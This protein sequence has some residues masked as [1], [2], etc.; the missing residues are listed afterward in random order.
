MTDEQVP[1]FD[2]PE[3]PKPAA[4]PTPQPQSPTTPYSEDPIDFSDQY[5]FDLRYWTY[6]DNLP[7]EIEHLLTAEHYANNGASTVWHMRRSGIPKDDLVKR[8]HERMPW[9]VREMTKHWLSELTVHYFETYGEDRFK[10]LYSHYEQCQDWLSRHGHADS[11]HPKVS[12]A[13]VRTRIDSER[14]ARD[15]ALLTQKREEVRKLERQ[16]EE[17]E[18]KTGESR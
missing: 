6:P 2:Q 13:D 7:Q 10:M 3:Q 4:A 11:K 18:G 14:L 9:G 17:L 1:L 15:R 8:A 12:Y 5:F 16:I